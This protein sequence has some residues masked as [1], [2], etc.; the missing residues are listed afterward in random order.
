[1]VRVGMIGLGAMGGPM[2]RNVLRAGFALSIWA[3]RPE[4]AD[5]LLAEGARWS[6]SPRD[7]ASASEVVILMVTS[8]PDV[9]RLVLHEGVLEGASPGS[10]IVDMSTIAPSVSRSVAEQCAHRG[11]SFLDAPVSGGT[12]GAEAGTL[13]VMVGGDAAALE[14]AR[15]VLEALSA[16]I[17]HIGP[18]GSG[19][20]VKLVNN[21]LVGVIAAATAE[22][23]VLGAKAG[24]DVRTMAEV[25]GASTGASWQLGNQ[26]P[27]RA[28]DGSFRPGFMTDLLVK[29]LGLALE[30]GGESRSPLFLTALARQLYGEAQAKGHGADDYTSVL[31][32]LESVA[33]VTVRAD[34]D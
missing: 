15:P 11:V 9:E 26:F 6:A 17:F 1:M 5:S 28:F 34:R 31:T 4:S 3:R 30:L 29:D 8:S 14:R 16:R 23:L 10:V 24:A 25:V 18:S 22:A 2:A 20:V 32:V 7:L 33:G 19:E 12:Q 27:L 21:V 13:T